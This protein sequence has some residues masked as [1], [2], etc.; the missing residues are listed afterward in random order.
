MF[1]F[2]NAIY[3]LLTHFCFV[4]TDQEGIEAFALSLNFFLKYYF[5]LII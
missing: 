5:Y 1:V 2:I 4:K 3:K